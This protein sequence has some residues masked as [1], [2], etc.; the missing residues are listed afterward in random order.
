MSTLFLQLTQ[1][2]KSQIV[3]LPTKEISEWFCFPCQ[4]GNESPKLIDHSEKSLQVTNILG[5]GRSLNGLYL[6]RVCLYAVFADHVSSK[7]DFSLETFAILRIKGCTCFIKLF[8]Y[9]L[10]PKGVRLKQNLPKGVINVVSKAESGSNFCFQNPELQSNLGKYSL[11]LAS[12][13]SVLGIG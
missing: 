6:L 7:F 10:I 13:F 5:C 2:L 4:M 3:V 9:C 12:M 11:I 8:K 1:V